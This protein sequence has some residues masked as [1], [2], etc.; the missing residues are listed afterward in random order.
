MRK[1]DMSVVYVFLIKIVQLGKLRVKLLEPM[2]RLSPEKTNPSPD[3]GFFE[4]LMILLVGIPI[5]VVGFAIFLIGLIVQFTKSWN[6]NFRIRNQRK[7]GDRVR[8][9]TFGEGVVLRSEIVEDVEFVDV[10]FQEKFG[11]KRVPTGSPIL[12]KL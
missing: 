10:Q 6:R 4:G 8:H 9:L 5:L 3:A 12:E 11:K 1:R 2:Y 7:P